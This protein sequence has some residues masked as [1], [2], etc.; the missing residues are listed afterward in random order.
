VTWDVLLV[1]LIPCATLPLTG[2]EY[3]R[4]SAARPAAIP[5]SG[6]SREQE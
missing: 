5:A 4:V 3:D 6:R 2:Q 1:L